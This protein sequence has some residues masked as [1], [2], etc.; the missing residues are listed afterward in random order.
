[1]NKKQKLQ[2]IK[3]LILGAL[4]SGALIYTTKEVIDDAKNHKPEQPK[5]TYEEYYVNV[6][7]KKDFNG[8]VEN[9]EESAKKVLKP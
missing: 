8:L 7:C 4:T 6:M 1:M 5:S 2:I 9:L 3:S